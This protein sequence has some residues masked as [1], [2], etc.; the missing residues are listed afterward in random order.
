MDFSWTVWGEKYASTSSVFKNLSLMWP[1]LALIWLIWLAAGCVSI[2]K[3]ALLMFSRQR[4]LSCC[5]SALIRGQVCCFF[6]RWWWWQTGGMFNYCDASANSPTACTHRWVY[7]RCLWGFIRVVVNVF[8]LKLSWCSNKVTCNSARVAST[9]CK[10]LIFTWF[11]HPESI[12]I[13]V[14]F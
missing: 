3:L 7:E 5:S 12:I 9:L 4:L 11:C 8:V 1:S 2:F 6:C 13:P 10:A 14:L